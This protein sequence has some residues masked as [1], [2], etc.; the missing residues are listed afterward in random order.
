[1]DP[2]LMHIICLADFPATAGGILMDACLADFLSV[3]VDL[4]MAMGGIMMDSCPTDFLMA[5]VTIQYVKIRT[6]RMR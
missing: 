4:I 3:V 6:G 2:L 5:A 1:M